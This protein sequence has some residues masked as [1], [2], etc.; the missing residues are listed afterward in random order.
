LLIRLL[1]PVA[2]NPESPRAHLK[3]PLERWTKN[4]LTSSLDAPD[5]VEDVDSVPPAGTFQ[6]AQ[7]S[8][9]WR[10]EAVLTPPH[11]EQQRRAEWIL[12]TDPAMRPERL[13]LFAGNPAFDAELLAAVRENWIAAWLYCRHLA[14]AEDPCPDD[15]WEELAELGPLVQDMLKSSRE[16]R[17]QTLREDIRRF[18]RTRQPRRSH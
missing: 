8:F 13:I 9:Q 16:K 12:G 17:H 10:L 2:Y 6:A 15:L 1:N 5:G 11:R 4:L 7:S 14:S 18:L 3:G